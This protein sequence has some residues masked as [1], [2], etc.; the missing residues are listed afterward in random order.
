MCNESERFGEQK[1][2][3]L[4][5]SWQTEERGFSHR[6]AAGIG[7][8]LMCADSAVAFLMSV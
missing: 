3:N 8:I 2:L 1:F 4:N 6:I 5:L 7:L